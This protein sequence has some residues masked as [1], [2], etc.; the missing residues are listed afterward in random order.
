MCLVS[1]HAARLTTS[2]GIQKISKNFDNIGEGILM[3]PPVPVSCKVSIYDRMADK[4]YGPSDH[5]C[6]LAHSEVLVLQD[7]LSISYKDAAHQ[8][9]M[10]ELERVKKD[11]LFFKAFAGLE[12]QMKKTPIRP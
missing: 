4:F 10:A 9:Y 3:F 2:E 8:L 12:T 11:Q 6:F 1:D 7:R 5:E